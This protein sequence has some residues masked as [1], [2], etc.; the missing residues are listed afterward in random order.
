MLAIPTWAQSRCLP[1]TYARL[2]GSSPTSTV[3]RPGTMPRSARAA[4]RPVSSAR[5]SA[6]AAFPSRI[7]AVMCQRS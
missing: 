2:P 1:F 4:T 7:R 3:P 5:I 6:A